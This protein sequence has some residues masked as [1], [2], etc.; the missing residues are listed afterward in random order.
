MLLNKLDDNWRKIAQVGAEGRRAP[1]A[2][3]LAAIVAKGETATK[4]NPL[5]RQR[6]LI[7]LSSVA[8][9]KLS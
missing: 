9:T 5:Q 4:K 8:A 2:S 7:R 3:R 6:F 1:Q